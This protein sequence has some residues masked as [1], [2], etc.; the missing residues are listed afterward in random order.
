MD[1]KTK[2][3]RVAIRKIKMADAPILMEM[4]NDAQISS[5]VVGTPSKVTLEEQI[6]WLENLKNE[7]DTI[8]FMVDFEHQPVGT[9]IIS[10]LNQS[11]KTG[12]M[13]IKLLPR[14]WGKGIAFSSMGLALDYCFQDLG[15]ECLTAH[16]LPFNQASVSLFLKL[17]FV[18]EGLLRS[19]VSKDNQRFDLVSFSLLKNEY[20]K[21]D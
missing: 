1:E 16:V 10:D 17:G 14:A 4:N 2:E 12:N 21:M 9:I 6:K 3:G 7:K 5:S 11:N 8:R 15:L 18:N 20:L 13:N 19:R